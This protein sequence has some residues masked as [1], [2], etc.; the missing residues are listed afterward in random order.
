MDITRVPVGVICKVKTWW[1]VSYN[2][3]II[4]KK[5]KKLEGKLPLFLEIKTSKGYDMLIDQNDIISCEAVEY[6][7]MYFKSLYLIDFCSEIM[8]IRK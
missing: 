8:D 4:D 5:R 3:T 6:D 7:E 2:G 1:G